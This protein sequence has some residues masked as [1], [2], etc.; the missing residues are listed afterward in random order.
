ME[1][2]SRIIY[3]ESD[4]GKAVRKGKIKYDLDGAL[5][6]VACSVF[7]ALACAWKGFGFDSGQTCAWIANSISARSEC[8]WGGNQLMCMTEM[9]KVFGKKDSFG[10]DMFMTSN[11]YRNYYV[12]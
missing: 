11:R 12:K 5:A 8:V 3:D 1:I 2:E 7:R 4:E 9:G 6:I 10:I